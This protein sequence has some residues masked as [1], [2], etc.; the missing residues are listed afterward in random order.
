MKTGNPSGS[1]HPAIVSV[2]PFSL[3]A[4]DEAVARLAVRLIRDN[5]SW[6][7]SGGKDEGAS[8]EPVDVWLERCRYADGGDRVVIEQ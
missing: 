6:P 5:Q 1:P 2:R 8:R 4:V 7:C 3:V